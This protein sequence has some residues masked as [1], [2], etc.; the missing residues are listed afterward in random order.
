MQQDI[1]SLYWEHENNI[2]ILNILCGRNNH[3]SCSNF[4]I[5]NLHQV[6]Y[7]YTNWLYTWNKFGESNYKA[8]DAITHKKYFVTSK[9]YFCQS[10][11]QSLSQGIASS[12]EGCGLNWACAVSHMILA[13]YWLEI[14]RVLQLSRVTVIPGLTYLLFIPARRPTLIR[15]VD[16]NS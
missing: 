7:I 3:L 13:C 15:G 14:L 4:S 10:N 9:C 12:H 6:L 8:G 11:L 1:E 16:V 5:A 2:A